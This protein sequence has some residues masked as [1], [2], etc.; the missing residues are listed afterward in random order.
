M[1]EYTASLLTKSPQGLPGCHEPP[2]GYVYGRVGEVHRSVGDHGGTV[3]LKLSDDTLNVG[4]VKVAGGYVPPPPSPTPTLTPTVTPTVTP[5]NTPPP[6]STP[7]PTVTPTVTPTPTMTMT[8]TPVNS[9]TPYPSPTPTMTMTMTPTMTMTVTPSNTPTPTPIPA[10]YDGFYGEFYNNSEVTNPI[11]NSGSWSNFSFDY[12]NTLPPV[13]GL[14]HTGSW[15]AIWTSYIIPKTTGNYELSGWFDDGLSIT[16]NGS[17][18]VDRFGEAHPSQSFTAPLG[19]LQSGSLYSLNVSYSQRSPN[20]ATLR[21]YYSLNGG[22]LYFLGVPSGP[23]VKNVVTSNPPKYTIPCSI[24]QLSYGS[25]DGR[26]Y[27]NWTDCS[28]GPMSL[29]VYGPPG[30]GWGSACARNGTMMAG[31]GAANLT[32]TCY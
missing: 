9:P 14:T 10:N 3:W 1:A 2:N 28:G 21:M 7:V 30:S 27:A 32:D 22:P 16:F 12:D 31:P 15:S 24:Y 23:V 29:D 4:W 25:G 11:V 13:D 18:V 19:T 6:S 17:V 20:R 26:L 8:E 5:T